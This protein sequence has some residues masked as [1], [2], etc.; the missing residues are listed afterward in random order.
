MLDSTVLKSIRG[1]SPKLLSV[2]EIWSS[3]WAALS[4]LSGRQSVQPGR[5]WGRGTQ[6]A[7][8]RSE[9]KGTGRIGRGIAW[10]GDSEQNVK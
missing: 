3:S 9:E 4:G 8:T 10:D 1:L 2:P 5:D 6:G 7:P